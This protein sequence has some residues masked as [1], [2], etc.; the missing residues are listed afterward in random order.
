M[1]PCSFDLHGLISAEFSDK[2]FDLQSHT[3]TQPTN[4]NNHVLYAS[5]YIEQSFLSFFFNNT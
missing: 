3:K 4:N 2:I 1:Y 5:S